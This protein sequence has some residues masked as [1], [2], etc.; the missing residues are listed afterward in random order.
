[1]E[2]C[3]SLPCRREGKKYHQRIVNGQLAITACY[4]EF[5][6]A[7]VTLTSKPTC[8]FTSPYKLE[9]RTSVSVL[10]TDN[11]LT[12]IVLV[13]F[14]RKSNGFSLTDYELKSARTR[15]TIK[16]GERCVVLHH[17][18]VIVTGCHREQRFGYLIIIC[19]HLTAK[20]RISKQKAKFI[21]VFRC[22]IKNKV[23]PLQT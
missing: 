7:I 5:G 13:Q 3:N 14:F 23:V 9:Y 12:F 11:L 16:N 8:R 17:F 2:E 1:M 21:L 20:V 18:K 19:L 15:N 22:R 6:T 10:T 4:Y